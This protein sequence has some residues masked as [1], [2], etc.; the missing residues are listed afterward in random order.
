VQPLHGSSL[1]VADSRGTLVAGVSTDVSRV[2]G[3]A[4]IPAMDTLPEITPTA[5]MHR[6]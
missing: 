2:R 5:A 4:R 3:P 1:A 6:I